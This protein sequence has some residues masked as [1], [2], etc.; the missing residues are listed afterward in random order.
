MLQAAN[1]NPEL[2]HQ[3]VALWDEIFIHVLL[4]LA[5]ASCVCGFVSGV[6][7]P[8]ETQQRDFARV[9]Q[10]LWQVKLWRSVPNISIHFYGF[11]Q[12]YFT[13]Y[14]VGG[15]VF[16]TPF[17]QWRE[18]NCPLKGKTRNEQ[19]NTTSK[20]CQT[21]PC[22]I[23]SPC[24]PNR[25][26]GAMSHFFAHAWAPMMCHS[27]LLKRPAAAASKEDDSVKACKK[28]WTIEKNNAYKRV[29]TLWKHAKTCK[30][31]GPMPF[32][33][34]QFST[35]TFETFHW[36]IQH[37]PVHSAWS[38]RMRFCLAWT[39]GYQLNGFTIPMISKPIHPI[40]PIYHL[41]LLPPLLG[42]L[43]VFLDVSE[44]FRPFLNVWSEW[45]FWSLL[46]PTI[47]RVQKL[48]RS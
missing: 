11:K 32:T 1:S 34:P 7:P 3:D 18:R 33:R 9:P 13:C 25:C 45:H 30:K 44:L 23:T 12:S 38:M 29:N 16:S 46:R 43:S 20:V 36:H 8:N 19:S 14:F 21:S 5:A 24:Q 47:P 31:K 22:Q 37:L 4:S 40:K 41:L 35:T 10:S 42:S 2:W 27:K 6:A 26:R 17:S 28:W 39:Q 48:L 15:V